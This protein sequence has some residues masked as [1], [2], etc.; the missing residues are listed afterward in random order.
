MRFSRHLFAVLLLCLPLAALAQQTGA[1]PA[2]AAA[3]PGVLNAEA[4]ARLLPAT[5][6]FAGQTAPVQARNSAGV[7]FADGLMLAALVDTSGYASDVQQKYQAYLLTEVPLRIA[8]RT[9]PAGAYGCGFVGG[10]FVVMD[11]GGRD[12]LRVPA[13][14]EAALRRPMPLQ[15]L[16]GGAAGEYRL[17]SGRSA[18]SFSE[19]K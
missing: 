17:L 15:V 3:A 16:A 8:D 11:I 13:A 10:A 14:S 6:F 5:V 18:V 2:A 1:A 19:S 7:R 12:L 4:A 9:L